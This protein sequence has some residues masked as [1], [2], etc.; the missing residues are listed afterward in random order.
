METDIP[1]GLTWWIAG[2]ERHEHD[3][4]EKPHQE[5]RRRIYR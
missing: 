2:R 5:K 3:H 4:D 1:L